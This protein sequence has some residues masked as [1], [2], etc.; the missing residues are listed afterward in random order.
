MPNINTDNPQEEKV[1]IIINNNDD[2]EPLL[3]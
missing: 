3:D 2:Y 1:I